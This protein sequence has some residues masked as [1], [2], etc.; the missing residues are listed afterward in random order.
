MPSAMTSVRSLS[1]QDSRSSR[2][3]V[4]D[5]TVQY[6]AVISGLVTSK[7]RGTSIDGRS[8]GDLSSISIPLHAEWILRSF[9]PSL[10]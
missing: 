5:C 1:V 3:E 2:E 10:L 4:Q 6:V 7:S 8:S 9:S